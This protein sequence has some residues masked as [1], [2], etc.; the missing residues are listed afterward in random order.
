MSNAIDTFWGLPTFYIDQM[1]V[2]EKS[3]G[4]TVEVTEGDLI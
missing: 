1:A 3:F 2:L 4:V